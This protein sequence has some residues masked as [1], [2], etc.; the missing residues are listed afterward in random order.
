MVRMSSSKITAKDIEDRPTKRRLEI[1]ETAIDWTIAAISIVPLLIT[2]HLPLTDLPNHL[3]RQYVLRDIAGSKVL[4]TF[5]EVHWSLVPNLALEIFVSFVGHLMSIDLAVRAFCILIVLSLFFGTRL[6][7]RTLGGEQSKV[8]RVA[9]LLCYGG[10][11]Q[12]G[13]LSF[14]FGIGLALLLFGFYLRLRNLPLGRLAVI[15]APC[16]FALLLCHLGAFG[17]FAAAVGSCELTDAFKS[18]NGSIHRLP[19]RIL[20]PLGRAAFCLLPAVLLFEIFSPTASAHRDAHFS[21]AWEKTEGLAAITLFS[22]PGP[23]LALLGFAVVGLLAAIQARVVRLHRDGVAMAVALTFIWL[24]LPR[25][26]LGGGYIDYR[27]PWAASFFLLSELVPGSRYDRFSVVFGTVFGV[28]AL[29]R[30]ALIAWFWLS[31]EPTLAAIDTA[32]SGLPAGVR[33]MVVEGHPASTS[34]SRRPPLDHVAAY[35]VARREAFEPNMFASFPG[36]ILYFREPYKNLSFVVHPSQLDHLPPEYNYVLVLRPA[37][38]RIS[39][40][41]DLACEKIGRDFELLKVVSL[42]ERLEPLERRGRCSG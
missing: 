31:W 17:I 3:A 42:E 29:A 16:S 21:N 39:P 28:L 37:L 24:I 35:A 34:A 40:L 26:A 25:V 1:R 12:F 22:S 15:F 20:G 7:N 6:I 11:F 38:T 9:P 19:A 10:P 27:V 18:A 23:E 4:Q 13:F 5:Y 8:Y 41:L 30:V 36:Q 32:L 33:L 14:C 2:Q